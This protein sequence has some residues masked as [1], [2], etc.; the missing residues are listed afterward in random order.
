MSI[1][2]NDNFHDVQEVNPVH[3]SQIDTRCE[4]DSKDCVLKIITVTQNYYADYDAMD[5]GYHPQAASEMKSKMSSRQKVQEYAGR[6]N[7]SFHEE[8]E[9]GNR[10]A[11]INDK[12]IKWAYDNLSDEARANYDKY[13]IKLV[14]G[15]DMGPYNEGPLWIWTYMDYSASEDGTQ[16]IVRSPMMRTS[17]SYP[18]KASRGFHYCK[19]LSP[20]KAIEWMML[21]GLYEND[22]IK[23][24]TAEL[25]LQ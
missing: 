11:E 5:T 18:V 3:L 17:T 14:T 8:D 9:V 21:D 25:F 20:F 4:E 24:Q 13:G 2:S 22:G 12:S 1:D 16:M 10:C 7:V 15:D 6:S 19:V 23:N